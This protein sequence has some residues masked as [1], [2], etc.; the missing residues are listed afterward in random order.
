[1]FLLVEAYSGTTTKDGELR[2]LYFVIRQFTFLERSEI[3]TF[4]R[5][6]HVARVLETN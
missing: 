3:N 1:M 6:F 2:I 4:T 5:P